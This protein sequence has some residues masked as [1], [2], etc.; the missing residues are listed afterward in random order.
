MLVFTR[1]PGESIMVGD[2]VTIKVSEVRGPNVRI[3][4]DAP[5]DVTI[6]R[7]EVWLRIRRAKEEASA[8]SD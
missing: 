8:N 6:H 5:R 2:D 4:I 3:A 1:R 7:R